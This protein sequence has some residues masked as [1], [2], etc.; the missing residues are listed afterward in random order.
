MPPIPKAACAYC[1]RVGGCSHDPK[2]QRSLRLMQAARIRE[3][4]LR[5]LEGVD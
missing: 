1:G 3:L 4:R 2:Y 5:E